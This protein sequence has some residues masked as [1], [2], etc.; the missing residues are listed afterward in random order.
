ML[1][2]R[3]DF[4]P[5]LADWYAREWPFLFDE[6]STALDEATGCSANRDSPDCT[7]VLVDGGPVAAASLLNEDVLPLPECSPWLGTVVV[8]PDRR[9]QGLGRAI[10]NCAVVHAAAI[11]IRTLHLWTPAHRAFYE[12]LGWHHLRDHPFRDESVAI[13]RLSLPEN[14]ANH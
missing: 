10:V 6:T 9:G 3:P 11:G 8:R 1:A 4:V 5:I 14:P 2:D 7:V 12:H 13:L